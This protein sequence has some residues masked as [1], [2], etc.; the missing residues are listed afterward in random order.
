MNAPIDTSERHVALRVIAMPRDTNIYGT[1]FGGIILSYID[2]AGFVEARRHGVHRW[3]TASMERVEFKSP[4]LVGDTVNFITRTI[5]RGRSSVQ[6]EIEVS[7]ERLATGRSVHVT[8]AKMTLVAV[9]ATGK[10]I[11]FDSPPTFDAHEP[12]GT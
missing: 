10:P 12:C 7:A 4:V 1:V 5:R 2:Q 3:V 6:V 8:Q 9:D 11:P